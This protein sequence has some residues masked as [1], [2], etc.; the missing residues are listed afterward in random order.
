MARENRMQP[1]RQPTHDENPYAAPSAS[2]DSRF[3]DEPLDLYGGGGAP[4]ADRGTR[5]GAAIID[6]LAYIAAALPGAVVGAM[7]ESEDLIIGLVGLGLLAM[8]GLNLYLLH[9]NGQTVGKKALGI[10]IVR[11]DRRTRAGLLRIFFLRMLPIGLIGNI[12][13]IGAIVQLVN[14][15]LIFRDSHQC[16]HDQFA[17]TIV[18]QDTSGYDQF[19]PGTPA[20]HTPW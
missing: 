16:L 18:V 13:F 7:V 4:L 20:T 3:D 5:L 15:L 1:Q 17:D 8:F 12:P 11:S 9:K 19:E 6:I 14:P 10:K 2:L